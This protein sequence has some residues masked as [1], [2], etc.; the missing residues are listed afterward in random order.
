VNLNLLKKL[1][2]AV[3]SFI[4]TYRAKIIG[5]T[6]A[7]V[8]LTAVGTLY[9]INNYDLP[10]TTKDFF[11]TSVIITDKLH[12]SGGSGVILNSYLSYSEVLT[13]KHVCSL[14]SNGGYVYK[15][16]KAFLVA[17]IKK[18]PTHDL[19][20]VK[21]HANFGI[22]TK[23]LRS[24]VGRHTPAFISGH[25]GLLPHVLTTG[26]FSSKMII[27]LMVGV[28]EC[29]EGERCG[30]FGNVP[31]IQSFEARLVTGT[32][33]PG[34]SGSGVFNAEGKISGLVFAGRGRGLGYAFIVPHEYVVDFVDNK[35][36]IP[37]KV[38]TRTK[39]DKM[40]DSIF[41]FQDKCLDNP[42]GCKGFEL[43]M[44]WRN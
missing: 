33:L 14:A 20:L 10:S 38:V 8:M 1:E 41:N 36:T 24:P 30:F 27:N 15:D 17:A 5:A 9:S 37:Y 43:Y 34:S 40:L 18:Y 23:V 22:N 26:H 28:R 4:D 21:V 11:N 16:G 44:I 7:L 39:Y 19:C 29:E 32:I 12:R 25:P 2:A 42:K 3:L 31:V 13:N 6:A 35:E